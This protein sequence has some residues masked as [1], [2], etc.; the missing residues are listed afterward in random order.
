MGNKK[1]ARQRK[2][3]PKKLAADFELED[4]PPRTSTRPKPRPT[5]KGATKDPKTVVDTGSDGD[6]D[7]LAGEDNTIEDFEEFE[8][9]SEDGPWDDEEDED[10]EEVQVVSKRH[11]LKAATAPGM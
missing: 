10:D 11:N 8:E 6:T 3:T 2:P 5:G 7:M 1:N 9:L 4:S